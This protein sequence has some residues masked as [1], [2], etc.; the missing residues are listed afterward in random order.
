MHCSHCRNSEHGTCY[1]V[2]IRSKIVLSEAS[3]YYETQLRNQHKPRDLWPSQT[4]GQQD[5]YNEQRTSLIGPCRSSSPQGRTETLRRLGL[6]PLLSAQRPM[7]RLYI[8]SPLSRHQHL[9]L[10]RYYNYAV[11]YHLA[12]SFHI[13]KCDQKITIPF[14]RYGVVTSGI[15][16]GS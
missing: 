7:L 12:R 3:S 11:R 13:K 10:F 6:K 2:V 15:H 5:D 1:S 16:F 14:A 8:I 9:S 4:G